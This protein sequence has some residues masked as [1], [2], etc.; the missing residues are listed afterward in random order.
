MKNKIKMFRLYNLFWK[1]NT[2]LK[3]NLRIKFLGL[4]KI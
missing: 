2:N 3:Q 1:K 4:N